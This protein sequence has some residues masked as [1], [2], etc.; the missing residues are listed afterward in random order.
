MSNVAKVT[1]P[2]QS[3]S[4]AVHQTV[5]RTIGEPVASPKTASQADVVE[6]TDY[7]VNCTAS[8]VLRAIKGIYEYKKWNGSYIPTRVVTTKPSNGI[9]V[10]QVDSGH[11]L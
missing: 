6:E 9:R 7:I 4:A 2:P 5:S 3:H 1:M 10:E 8:G 11:A